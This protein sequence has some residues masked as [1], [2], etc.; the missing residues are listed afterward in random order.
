MWY[1]QLR[2]KL[3]ISVHCFEFRRHTGN[4]MVNNGYRNDE[5]VRLAIVTIGRSS[6]SYAPWLT[7]KAQHTLSNYV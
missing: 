3:H 5:S 2:K 4:A 6:L 7:Q 1:D